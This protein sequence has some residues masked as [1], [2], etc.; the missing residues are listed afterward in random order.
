MNVGDVKTK[1]EFN[2]V[3]AE[4]NYG[5]SRSFDNMFSFMN[6]C[7]ENGLTRNNSVTYWSDYLQT[8]FIAY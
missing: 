6:F 7:Y 1:K 8:M 5:K 4:K 3:I 2:S